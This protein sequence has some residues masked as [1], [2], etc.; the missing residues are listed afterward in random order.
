MRIRLSMSRKHLR[1]SDT[2]PSD[3]ICVALC[4]A[5][6]A[7]TVEQTALLPCV[8]TQNKNSRSVNR[9]NGGSYRHRPE[10]LVDA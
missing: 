4:A 8:H 10:V 3:L 7:T 2:V 5:T 9:P 6:V 1:H